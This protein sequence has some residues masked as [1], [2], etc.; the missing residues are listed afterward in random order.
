MGLNAVR[1]RK[2]CR[3]INELVV[4]KPCNPLPLAGVVRQSRRFARTHR[5]V[6]RVGSACTTGSESPGSNVFVTPTH[7]F[8][9]KH[10]CLQT[11][12]TPISISI[13]E[14]DG[15]GAS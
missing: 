6:A 12:L 3:R 13:H 5:Q 1:V 2:L 15:Y 10:L 11:E 8:D 9:V 7:C 4:F 14:A